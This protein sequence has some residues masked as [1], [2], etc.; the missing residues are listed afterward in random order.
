MRYRCL[1]IL[2]IFLVACGPF[3]RP[4]Y[5][6]EIDP[7]SQAV[8]SDRVVWLA[9]TDQ[10]IEAVVTVLKTFDPTLR[11]LDIQ[12]IG[13]NTTKERIRDIGSAWLT[14]QKLLLSMR[15]LG[16]KVVIDVLQLDTD[17]G[18]VDSLPAKLQ[19]AIEDEMD[20]RFSR[21]RL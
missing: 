20:K 21:S 4:S 13:L 3:S 12:V 15:F 7:A 6:E 9:G 16:D 14:A 10:A 1:S 17:H 11:G 8:S 5:F 19:K 2:L 18:S